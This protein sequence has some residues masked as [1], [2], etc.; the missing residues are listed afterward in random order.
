M[1]RLADVELEL[2][3]HGL[4]AKE[5]L[6]FARC[7]RRLMHLASSSFAWKCATL[8]LD[9]SKLE[10]RVITPSGLL[11][12][13]PV[14]LVWCSKFS[15]FEGSDV[16][17]LLAIARSLRV[18]ELDCSQSGIIRLHIF[19]SV[20]AAPELNDLRVLRLRC[21]LTSDHMFD[22]KCARLIC[23]LPKLHTLS[24]VSMRGEPDAW[25]RLVD[26]PSLT[27]LRVEDSH[28]IGARSCLPFIV[29]C[30][31]VQRLK[32]TRPFL[33][34]AA[35]REFCTAPTIAQNLQRLELDTFFAA[36]MDTRSLAAVSAVDYAASFS[37]L[38][39]LRCLHL[40]RVF[41]LN[42]L[43]PHLAQAAAL[44]ELILEPSCEEAWET[45]GS[46]PASDV[47]SALLSA[48]AALHVSLQLF[49]SP[50]VRAAVSCA[51]RSA[52]VKLTRE[53]KP[54]GLRFQCA[55]CT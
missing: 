50:G 41:G 25:A 7:S 15:K 23:A 19:R 37:A 2:C 16:A 26:A 14:G 20:L 35:F 45:Q 44:T 22:D 34:G 6:L 17:S 42:A 29:K 12:H 5:I 47:L 39:S 8:Q 52:C 33:Y 18:R 13:A 46:M 31:T 49:Y 40:R 27:D 9:S 51:M 1:N 43:L 3:M 36:G 38:R 28:D 55:H 10:D 30:A 54:F 4:E 11:L 32:V 48:S 21:P 24:V 53:M